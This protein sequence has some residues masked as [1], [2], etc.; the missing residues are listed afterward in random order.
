MITACF[1]TLNEEKNLRKCLNNIKTIV[2][3]IVV[4][5]AYSSDKTIQVAQEFGSEV[6]L[7]KFKDFASQR[8]YALSKVKNSWVLMIDPDETCSEKMLNLLPK[9]T[10]RKY[11]AYKFYWRNYCGDRLVK[12]VW[13][14]ALF[15]SFALYEEVVHERIDIPYKHKIYDREVYIVHKKNLKEQAKHLKFYRQVI[16]DSYLKSKSTKRIDYLIKDH[17]KN[18]TD[19]LGKKYNYLLINRKDLSKLKSAHLVKQ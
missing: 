1:I 6:Y 16:L 17:N 13:K 19:W 11:D 12:V 15:R 5:D 3:K 14:V 8:N 10:H 9:L 7:H 2:D 4:V 18:V